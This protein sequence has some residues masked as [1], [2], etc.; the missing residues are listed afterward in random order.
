MGSAFLKRRLSPP[1][2]ALIM[3]SL[4]GSPSLAAGLDGPGQSDLRRAFLAASA[5]SSEEPAV[6]AER[7]QREPSS[8]FML[9]AA[10]G[11]W[12]EARYQLDF[13][14]KTPGAAGPPHVSQNGAND[15]AIEQ[16]CA[17]EKTAF[18][19]LDSRTASLGLDAKSVLQMAA[20]PGADAVLV[21][22]LARRSG[23][24]QGCR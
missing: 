1:A 9:G 18:Q 24:D 11:A 14:L 13:D 4:Q 21:R 8:G 3:A 6:R 17:D 16:D 5:S 12:T 19:R 20:A 22:W 23:P 2:L 15:E 7:L 10:L